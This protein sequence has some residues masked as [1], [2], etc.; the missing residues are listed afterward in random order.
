MGKSILTKYT[1]TCIICGAQQTIHQHHL[2]F[3]SDR[4]KAD[5]DGLIVPLCAY[6][7]DFSP[8]SVHLNREMAAMSKIIGELAWE[9]EY[10]SKGHTVEE[11]KEAFMKRYGKAYL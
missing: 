6:H 4:K 1:N 7:H 11:A 9:R 5:E 2:I 8:N 3:G 10:C